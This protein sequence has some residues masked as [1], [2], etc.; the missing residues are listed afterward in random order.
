MDLSFSPAEEGFRRR[1]RRWLADNPPEAGED[2]DLAVEVDRLRRWQRRLHDGGWIGLHWPKEYGGAGASPIE[3][4]I[5]AEE[6]AR[7]RSPELIGRIGLNL[8]GP[9]LIA[10]GTDAQ[11]RRHLPRILSAEHLWCQLFSEP[12]AGSDLASLRTRATAD[13]DS[14]VVTGRKLWT[15]Y[16]QFADFGILLARTDPEAPK[17]RGIGMLIVDVRSRGVEVRPLRQMTGTAEF[18][19]VL[20]EDV[21]VP[22]EN[23]LGPPTEGWRIAGT[24]LAHERGLNPRQMVLQ[25]QAIEDLL[26][27][28]RRSG[29]HPSF[30]QQIAQS[31][32][33]VEIM[34]LSA[35]RTLTRVMRGGKPGPEGSLH[36]LF[37]SEMSQRMNDVA[38]AILGAR[39]ALV[40]GSRHAVANGRWPRSLLYSR[41]TTI[42]AGTSE[43]QRNVLA[44][45][46]LGLPRS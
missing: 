33:E 18:N 7:A 25:R 16:A 32:I 4:F 45:R 30:R 9:T 13:G 12:E 43:I 11:K 31:W 17:H 44:E 26:V 34:R 2:D 27:L 1:L 10:H 3:S 20:F 41:A 36:K 40:R 21:R 23:L 22:R 42:F 28:A 8:V 6:L 37:W 29:F 15:S 24:T 19:E 35:F 14:F 38:F 46:V 39:G 5:L